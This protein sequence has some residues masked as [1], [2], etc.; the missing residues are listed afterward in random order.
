[1]YL[2]WDHCN[3]SKRLSIQVISTWTQRAREEG[4]IFS[5]LRMNTLTLSSLLLLDK[6]NIRKVVVRFVSLMLSKKQKHRMSIFFGEPLCSKCD[7]QEETAK[8]LIFECEC[9]EEKRPE[10]IGFN[11]VRMILN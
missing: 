4:K 5:S 6:G 11:L 2:E 9:L 1:M 8:H 10:T 3:I 7:L